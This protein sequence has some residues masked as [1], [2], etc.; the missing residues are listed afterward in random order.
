[1]RKTK[2]KRQKIKELLESRKKVLELIKRLDVIFKE[3][4]ENEDF[5]PG[6][7]GTK[8]QMAD[9]DYQVAL[10]QLALIDKELKNLGVELKNHG[11]AD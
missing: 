1:M 6:H 8:Y 7:E 4:K 10:S 11:K 9:S 5:W 2:N 3:E